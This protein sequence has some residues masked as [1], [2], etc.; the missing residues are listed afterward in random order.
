[1]NEDEDRR[2]LRHPFTFKLSHFFPKALREAVRDSVVRGVRFEQGAAFAFEP[3]V[4]AQR[5]VALAS[6]AEDYARLYAAQRQVAVEHGRALPARRREDPEVCRE[7]RVEQ[8]RERCLRLF[9]V[10]RRRVPEPAGRDEAESA[11]QRHEL[12]EQRECGDPRRHSQRE[13]RRAGFAHDEARAARGER[14]R[15]SVPLRRVG[16]KLRDRVRAALSVVT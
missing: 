1:M 11:R 7:H 9:R 4:A 14:G 2:C 8:T 3:S 16:H 12:Y 6:H 13:Q 5:V 15:S 10:T